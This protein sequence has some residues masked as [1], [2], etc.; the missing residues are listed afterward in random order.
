MKIIAK[1]KYAKIAP[2]KARLVVANIKKEK[3]QDAMEKLVYVPNKAAN[4]ISKVIKSA[5]FNAE[6]N[7]SLRKDDLTIFE[8]RIDGAPFY[9]RVKARAKG[10][11]DLIKKRTSHITVTLLSKEEPAKAQAPKPKKIETPERIE[12]V[13]KAKEKTK[14]P[15]EEKVL[16]EEKIK[17]EQ[18][19][20]KEQETKLIKEEKKQVVKEK[21]PFFTRIFRRKGGA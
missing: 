21:K 7:Y 4:L 12:K 5:I 1:A 8:I 6:N 19:L 3:A 17:K 20:L 11:R 14:E 2:R 13:K 15:T 10:G 18:E 16:E 9:K